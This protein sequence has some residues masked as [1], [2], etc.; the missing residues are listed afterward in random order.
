MKNVFSSK[1]LLPLLALAMVELLKC[2]GDPIAGGSG[3]TTTNGITAAIYKPGGAPA[4]GAV[5]KMRS[6]AFLAK[7]PQ[8]TPKA[9]QILY[10]TFTD[11]LGRFFIPVVERGDY[12]IEINDGSRAVLL[13]CTLPGNGDTIVLPSDTVRTYAAVSGNVDV[14]TVGRQKLFI[15]VYGMERLVG[16]DS[17]GHFEVSDLPAGTYRFRVA[18]AADS[19]FIPIDGH[20]VTVGPGESRSIPFVLWSHSVKIFFNTTAS[21]AD[22]AG[23]VTSFPL[24]V[25]LDA[26]NFDFNQ[27]QA[28]GADVRFTKPDGGMLPYEIERWELSGAQAEIWVRADTIFGNSSTQYIVMYWGNSSANPASAP[29]AV[30]DTAK[31]FQGVWHLDEIEGMV[32]K[33]ATQN[34]YDGIPF[35]TTTVSANEGTIGRAQKFDGVSSYIAMPY[36]G[37]SK[38]DFPQLSAYSIS[39]WLYADT[40][41]SSYSTIISKGLYDY[42]LQLGD[43]NNWGFLDYLDKIGWEKVSSPATGKKWTYLNAVR[44]GPKQYFYVDGVCID[45]STILYLCDSARS[46]A[47]DFMIGKSP[48]WP[49]PYLFKGIIDEVRVSNVVQ[50]ADWVRLCFMNQK[51][52]DALVVF[53]IK[54]QP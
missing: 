4:I 48:N 13:D 2:A 49:Q 37:A 11:D 19:L 41:D 8:G 29:A 52:K 44:S 6:A 43:G 45:S 26:A 16:V 38:L 40:L 25:R 10:D 3:S 50:S 39:T 23:M 21:G 53:R 35:G 28:N 47:N 46:V 7:V 9:A 33:D 24:L 36:T 31:G 5:V 42:Y 27:A 15:Q 18:A 14:A 1:R 34:H 17:T 20:D 22:V 51:P 30:F 12:R 54:D 32:I